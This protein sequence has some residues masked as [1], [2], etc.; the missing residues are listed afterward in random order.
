MIYG[1]VVVVLLGLLTFAFN[2]LLP[3]SGAVIFTNFFDAFSYLG[4]FLGY[5]D[6]LLPISE[7]VEMFSTV[8]T[9][10]FLFFI[11][12]LIFYG[13]ALFRGNDTPGRP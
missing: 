8:M 3:Y 6:G 9:I 13:V 2:V 1:V 4:G 7:V 11:V 5:A 12:R 10:V